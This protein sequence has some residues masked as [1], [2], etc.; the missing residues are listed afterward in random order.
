M[1]ETNY[2]SLV[3]SEVLSGR[4]YLR[5]RVLRPAPRGSHSSVPSVKAQK[6]LNPSMKQQSP[7]RWLAT[8]LN[9]WRSNAHNRP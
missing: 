4:Y 2:V 6:Y 5:D 8:A 1:V 3:T 9:G 7:D